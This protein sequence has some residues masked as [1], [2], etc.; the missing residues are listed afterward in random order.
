M[1]FHLSSVLDMENLL[2]RNG[3]GKQCHAGLRLASG[4]GRVFC[5][6]DLSDLPIANCR[7][8]TDP[9]HDQEQL[10]LDGKRVWLGESFIGLDT[11]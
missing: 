8:F 11:D 7:V 5:L 10:R 6:D 2:H 1:V 9:I 3:G 4:F